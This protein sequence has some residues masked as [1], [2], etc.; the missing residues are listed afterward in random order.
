M[1]QSVLYIFANYV[2]WGEKSGHFVKNIP[3]DY[4]M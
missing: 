1:E 3:H 2:S 4:S